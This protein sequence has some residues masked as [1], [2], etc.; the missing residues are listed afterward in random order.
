[1]P[2]VVPHITMMQT[3]MDMEFPL[4]NALAIQLATIEQHNQVTVKTTIRMS[5]PIKHPTLVLP[6]VITMETT[7][8][9]TIVE[10][11]KKKRIP[12]Q[13]LAIMITVL[14]NGVH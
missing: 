5:V 4:L 8:M 3:M 9:I 13:D 10:M 14:A 7:P 11:V 1:M 2:K 6:T 12:V